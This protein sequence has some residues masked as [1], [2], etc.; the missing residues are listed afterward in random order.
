MND[1]DVA[2]YYIIDIVLFGG[3]LEIYFI[4]MIYTA[5]TDV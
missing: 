2:L 4:I 1:V 5:Q 3:Y